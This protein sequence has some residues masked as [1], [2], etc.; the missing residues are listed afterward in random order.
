MLEPGRLLIIDDE[1]SILESLGAFFLD[2]GFQIFKALDGHQGLEIFYDQEIDLV[3][4][5]LKMPD[6]DGFK[7]M[8]SIGRHKPETP[9][10]VISGAGKK[11]D[12]IRAL[13]MGAKDYITKPV[14]DLD[15]IRH[16]V[17]RVLEARKL[18]EENLACRLQLQES[19]VKYRS[20][21]E[22]IAEGVFTVD[23]DENFTYANQAFSRMT[24]FSV[25]SILNKNLKD[26]TT[27]RSFDIILEQTNK[28]MTGSTDRYSVEMIASQNQTIH[29]ELACSPI[30]G[31]NRK[32]CG[33]IA[34]ARDITQIISLRKI[35][36]NISKQ[37]G[38]ATK[39]ITAICAACKNIRI[40]KGEWIP[41]EEHFHRT[42]FSHG[43][44]PVCCD[45]LY[46]EFSQSILKAEN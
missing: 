10:I 42:E 1:I 29:V 35:Y 5:D 18:S 21:T 2:E 25:E 4:T 41:V 16:I 38:K 26:V 32:Y 39:G 11:Q 43:L 15:M 33:A 27:P 24:G 31:D 8:E 30:F 6:I 13:R 3:L 9:V 46:P 20:I 45:K 7:V 12:I 17:D 37:Q 44:C 34:V 36:E 22:N 14:E 28:R 40:R 23:E 19:E